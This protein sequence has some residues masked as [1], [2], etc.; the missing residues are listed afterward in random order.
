V[1]SKGRRNNKHSEVRLMGGTGV[2]DR[3]LEVFTRYIIFGDSDWLRAEVH[4]S[5]PQL[6]EIDVT[7]AAILE[8]GR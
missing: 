6:A 7:L 4:F 1:G 8:L 2:I 3:F 5:P